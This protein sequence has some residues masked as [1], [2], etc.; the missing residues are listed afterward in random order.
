[1]IPTIRERHG[2]TGAETADFVRSL[3]VNAAVFRAPEP[4]TH[5]ARDVTDSRFLSLAGVSQADYLVT[6]DRR[7]LL[8]LRKHGK[9]RFVTPT[10][11]L[12]IID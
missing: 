2:R 5:E 11:F 4:K 6:K 7:H 12:R 8:R 9:T 1:M 10:Q 3:V